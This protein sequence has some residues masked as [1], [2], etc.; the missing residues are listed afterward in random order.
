MDGIRRNRATNVS[1]LNES[2]AKRKRGNATE[3]VISV[4]RTDGP[5]PKTSGWNK[6]KRGR[7]A[8]RSHV[9]RR[10]AGNSQVYS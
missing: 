10:W 3:A 5:Q 2:P 7:V 1:K 9:A 6:S 4:S 8:T